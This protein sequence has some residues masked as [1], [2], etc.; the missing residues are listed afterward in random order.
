[1]D[2]LVALSSSRMSFAIPR[3]VVGHM[4]SARYFVTEAER[5]Q[6]AVI[7]M[8]WAAEMALSAYRGDC[9]VFGSFD[10]DVAEPHAGDLIDSHNAGPSTATGSMVDRHDDLVRFDQPYRRASRLDG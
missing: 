6:G 10:S 2:G 7:E 8:P 5:R 1:M 3:T 4:M 9:P